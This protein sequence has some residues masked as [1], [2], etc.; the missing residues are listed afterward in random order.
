MLVDSHCHLTFPDFKDDVT[1][2]LAR[3]KLVGIETFLS[4]CCK[5]DEI[6]LLQAFT[7][8]HPQ[9]YCSVGIHPHEATPTLQ[10]TPDLK[11][12]IEKALKFEKVVGLGETGLDYYY[13]N[14]SRGDQERSFRLHCE[15]ALVHDLPLIIHTRDAEEDTLRVLDDYPGVKG[16]F[17]C[18]SGS[19]F[20]AQEALIRGFFLSLSGILTF[21]TAED[22]RQAIALAPLDR[23]LLETDSPYLAPIPHR[24]KRNEPAFMV[25]T[26]KVLASIK[27]IPFEEV[28]QATTDNFFRLFSRARSS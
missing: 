10:Q 9:V 21:K 14:S 15:L 4:I 2:V 26:A 11:A 25:E 12:V 20:L 18:F 1:D 17:H 16:V 7:S 23:L 13:E 24:G 27:S 8:A 5:L 3:A 22:L 19:Q 6:E 28:T